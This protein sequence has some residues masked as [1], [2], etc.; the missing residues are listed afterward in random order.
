MKKIVLGLVLLLAV[1]GAQAQDCST[2]KCPAPYDLTSG[3]SIG[4][5]T[6]L[7]KNSCL[8]KLA[9]NRSEERR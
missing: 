8:K 3:F 7:V 4:M 9:K 2:L 6:V 5:S 1:Q